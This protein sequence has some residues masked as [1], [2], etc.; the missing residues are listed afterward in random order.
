MLEKATYIKAERATVNLD[1]RPE[2]FDKLA[3]QAINKFST[4]SLDEIRWQILE[5]ENY[6]RSLYKRDGAENLTQIFVSNLIQHRLQSE[7]P[8]DAKLK[9]F[10]AGFYWIYL[11]EWLKYFTYGK[12]RGSKRTI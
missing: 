6:E 1:K 7:P 9:I 10:Y 2:T 8:F 4:Q 12:D 3:D 5:M 11:S